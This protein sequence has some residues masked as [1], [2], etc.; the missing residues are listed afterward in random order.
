MHLVWREVETEGLKPLGF[1]QQ[2][3]VDGVI[4]LI[5]AGGNMNKRHL[6][7]VFTVECNRG[8]AL[9]ESQVSM[10]TS[11]ELDQI[12]CRILI[13]LSGQQTVRHDTECG[14]KH[15]KGRGA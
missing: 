9:F 10:E 15:R 8:Q 6:I 14:E 2:A 7:G 1:D 5:V 11:G 12:G 4:D 3:A 13:E